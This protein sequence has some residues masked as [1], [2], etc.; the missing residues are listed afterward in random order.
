MLTNNLPEV[1]WNIKTH[2]KLAQKYERMHGEIYN[3]IE[4]SRLLNELAHAV[5]LI[6]TGEHPKL[7]LDFGCGA[8]N[9]TRHLSN[10]GCDVIATDV[11]EGFLDLVKSRSYETKVETLML[12]GNNLVTVPDESVDFVATYSVLHHV[13]D[14]LGIL[15]EFMRVLKPGGIIYIDHEQSDSF[16]TDDQ[17]YKKFIFEMKNKISKDYSKYFILTNYYD[18][19]IRKFINSRYQREG[20]LHVF[21]DDHIEWSKVIAAIEAAGGKILRSQDYL[22]FRRGFDISIYNKYSNSV[23]DMHVLVMRKQ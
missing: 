15:S 4:Q 16:W 22:L 3:S 19:F 5:S 6:T 14:Y 10:L 17:Q 8:G 2:N 7:A 1:A 12:N 18:W 9:L 11:A 21:K 20:D 13:P 23:S